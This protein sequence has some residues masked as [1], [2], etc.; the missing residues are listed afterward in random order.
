MVVPET[1]GDDTLVVNVEILPFKVS[2]FIVVPDTTAELT[3]LAVTVVPE[4]IGLLTEVVKIP[5]LPFNVSL[6]MVVPETTEAFTVEELIVTILAL[7]PEIVVPETKGEDTLVVNI[8]V[9]PL[10]VSLLM[11]VPET[12]FEFKVEL[13]TVVIEPVFPEIVVPDNTEVL[14][15]VLDIFVIVPEVTFNCGIVTVKSIAWEWSLLDREFAT[16]V[17]LVVV[18]ESGVEGAAVVI[19]SAPFGRCLVAWADTSTPSTVPTL[20]MLFVP[21]SKFPDMALAPL[22]N[23]Y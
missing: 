19:A 17:S 2:L 23:K 16:P 15:V 3:V 13:V 7:F 12:T 4:T 21:I 1:N 9:L 6:L 11:V 18:A 14:M 22:A 5:R 10:S 20:V 8:P